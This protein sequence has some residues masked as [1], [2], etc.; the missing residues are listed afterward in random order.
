MFAFKKKKTH[1]VKPAD[2]RDHAAVGRHAA[3][4]DPVFVTGQ[5]L[6]PFP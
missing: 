4:A 1:S 3:G 2:R 6:N 5:N